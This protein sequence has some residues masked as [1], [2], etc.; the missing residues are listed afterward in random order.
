MQQP[1]PNPELSYNVCIRF[2]NGLEDMPYR[3]PHSTTIAQLKER[4][5]T[6]RA[7]QT[8]FGG[9][10]GKLLKNDPPQ[11]KTEVSDLSDKHLRLLFQGR[12]LSDTSTLQS[13]APDTT[14]TSPDDQPLYIHCV[15]SDL[16]PSER[17]Q[18]PQIRPAVG[19]DRLLEIGFSQEEVQSVRQHFHNL[20]GVDG[21]N[22]AARNAEEEWI[23]NRLSAAP[24]RSDPDTNGF[25]DLLYGLVVGFFLGILAF[26][27]IKEPGAFS[28]RQ[29]LAVSGLI[30]SDLPDTLVKVVLVPPNPSTAPTEILAMEVEQDEVPELPPSLNI[31][32]T[33]LTQPL[34]SASSSEAFYAGDGEG[35]QRFA[36]SAALREANDEDKA[37]TEKDE[38][39]GKAKKARIYNPRPKLDAERLLSK[40]GIPHILG[41]SR[42]IKFKG[43]GHGVEDLEKLMTFYNIWAHNLFPKMNF[44]DFVQKTE[45]VCRERRVRIFMQSVLNE[46]RRAQMGVDAEH[47]D[48]GGNNE[49]A[50]AEEG[51]DVDRDEEGVEEGDE[52]GDG[53]QVRMDEDDEGD[54]W[55]DKAFGNA[56]G[57]GAPAVQPQP[58]QD[59]PN[60]VA[61]KDDAIRLAGKSTDAIPE[62][63]LARIEANRIQAL[64]RLE[65]RKR[66][67]EMERRQ[68][69]EMEKM[70]EGVD[71][72]MMAVWDME[73]D[74]DAVTGS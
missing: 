44:Q 34:P 45:K 59:P 21:R 42:K 15:A 10:E 24:P 56:G 38:K 18:G 25:S 2:A 7:A 37:E 46:Y 64:A 17:A 19:F 13:L 55:F 3:L 35:S 62:D 70:M 47:D 20:R 48:D 8:A 29:Q 22:E 67:R 23:D 11:V 71:A 28:R 36:S 39:R 73:V 53:E 32:E 65:E 12:I 30:V 49:D 1:P 26:F 66:R 50:A 40:K 6:V 60:P 4:V 54:G 9:F 16:P 5:T 68:E 43:K 51:G 52:R 69:L 41:V 33:S 57:G 31:D 27:V 58:P 72:E 14:F 63:V 61:P 74:N